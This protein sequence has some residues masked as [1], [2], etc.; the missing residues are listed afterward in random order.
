MDCRSSKKLTA[1]VLAIADDLKAP[2]EQV[3]GELEY[4]VVEKAKAEDVQGIKDKYVKPEP[5]FKKAANTKK[6]KKNTKN[7]ATKKENKDVQY[8]S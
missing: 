8:K 2:F 4:R 7:P 3:V 5:V 6:P 1:L